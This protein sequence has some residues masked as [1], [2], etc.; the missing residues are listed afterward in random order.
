[1]AFHASQMFGRNIL[2]LLKH[3]VKDGALTLDPTDEITGA[4]MMTHDG[5]GAS[6]MDIILELYV[7]VLAA[8]VGYMVITRVPPLLHTPLMA[9]TNAISGI[10]L[11]GSLIAAGSRAN[12]RRDDP[13]LHRRRLRDE[14]HRRRIP[15]HRSHA[16]DVQAR[17]RRE[18]QGRERRP[19]ARSADADA[20]HFI[21]VSYLVASVLFILGLR[22]LTRPD[23]ARR[24]MQLA[25]VG[26]AVRHRR[27]AAQ[28]HDRRLPLDR[29]RARPRRRHRL[30]DG[31]VGADDGDAA[32]HRALAHASARSRRRSSASPSTTRTHGGDV[33]SHARRWRR[34]ASRCMLGSLT[35]GGTLVAAGKLQEWITSQ[36]GDVQGPERSSTALLFLGDRSAL[37]VYLDRRSRRSSGR[38][39]R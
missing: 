36:A 11:V 20:R 1:M 23:K 15:H 39:T 22:S 16:E 14:Q 29:R 3:L 6:L 4:M 28:P 2:E 26:H 10:S 18:A 35:V 17:A 31:H 8:F 34:S 33:P 30:P 7:F 12:T 25:A 38:S 24:G 27:H 9:A 37:F 32:A 5:A 13:R 19:T 21:Q